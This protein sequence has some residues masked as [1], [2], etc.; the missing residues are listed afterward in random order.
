[1]E[2]LIDLEIAQGVVDVTPDFLRMAL[3][4]ALVDGR[5]PPVVEVE[6]QGHRRVL[7]TA[8]RARPRGP[9]PLAV[10]PAERREV[11]LQVVPPLD[12]LLLRR[13]PDVAHP[14]VFPFHRDLRPDPLRLDGREFLR[15]GTHVVV[16][17]PALGAAQAQS[18]HVAGEPEALGEVGGNAAVGMGEHELD[19]D[20]GAV[21]RETLRVVEVGF[22]LDAWHEHGN[23]GVGE[24]VVLAG[25]AA[26]ERAAHDAALQPGPEFQADHAVTHLAVV[27]AEAQASNGDNVVMEE[28]VE[29]V[30]GEP[31]K[32][33]VGLLAASVG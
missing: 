20:A 28:G 32:I 26:Q 31:D 7:H 1:M 2:E 29:G 14:G 33:P 21:P 24:Q 8:V 12:I 11:G 22:L 13:A 18:V 4:H 5:V 19:L 15:Q 27:V 9:H 25:R 23:V 17:E 3:S 10:L 6:Q 16:E 30:P